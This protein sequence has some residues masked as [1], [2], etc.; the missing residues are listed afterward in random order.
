MW[1]YF[2]LFLL[3]YNAV[4]LRRDKSILYNRTSIIILLYFFFIAFVALLFSYFD[5]SIG[6]YGG[7]FYATNITQV[8]HIFIFFISAIILQ[9]TSFYLKKVKISFRGLTWGLFSFTHLDLISPSLYSYLRMNTSLNPV[10]SRDPLKFFPVKFL[11]LN[12]NFVAK[13]STTSYPNK[14]AN[15]FIVQMQNVV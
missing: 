1:T 3:L 7:L 6:L 15:S 10:L 13:Y 4:T 8:F 11:R 2:I 12:Q 5:S 14:T 9:L